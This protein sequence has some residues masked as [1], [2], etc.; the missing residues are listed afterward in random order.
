MNPPQQRPDKANNHAV[1]GCFPKNAVDEGAA[2]HPIDE[3]KVVDDEEDLGDQSRCDKDIEKG[4]RRDP[5]FFKQ[6][7]LCQV[8]DIEGEEEEDK[9]GQYSK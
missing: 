3:R 9:G 1:D 5:R 6:K 8:D 7:D 4:K 2:R